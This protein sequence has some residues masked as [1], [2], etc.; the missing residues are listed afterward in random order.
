MIWDG[1]VEEA[2]GL[3]N[4]FEDPFELHNFISLEG[5]NRSYS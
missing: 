3:Y 1:Q 4:L 5:A 2:S